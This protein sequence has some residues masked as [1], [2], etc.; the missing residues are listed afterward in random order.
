MSNRVKAT[1]KHQPARWQILGAEIWQKVFTRLLVLFT[2]SLLAVS[3]LPSLLSVE[4]S[5]QTSPSVDPPSQNAAP[6]A[7]S[8]EAMT[9]LLP[10]QWSLPRSVNSATDADTTETAPIYLDGRALFQLGAP[11]VEGQNAAELRAQEIQPKLNRIAK[12][13]LTE[14]QSVEVMIDPPSQLP[15]ITVSNELLLTVTS[16]DAQQNGYLERNQYAIALKENI[17][18]ALER[19]RFERQPDFIKQ[20]ARTAI[21]I[22][23]G[24]LL[25]FALSKRLQK[26]LKKKQI[27]LINTDTQLG[28]ATAIQ[29]R[30]PMI[31]A[32]GVDSVFELIKARLDNRQ[33]RKLNELASGLLLLFQAGILVGATLWILS[34]FPYSRWLATLLRHWI[35][36]PATMLLI[37]GLAYIAL[38]I[39]S[40]MVD[41]TFLALQEGA[42]WAPESSERLSLRLITFS[43]VTKGIAGAF[44]FGVMTLAMLSTAGIEVGPLLAGAGIIG[45]GISL[46]AQGL[47][48]DIINGFLIL[49]EDQFGVGDIIAVGDISGSVESINLRITRLRNTEGRLITIPNS[50]IGIV[51]NL[52]KD[53]SQVDLFVS[54]EP[55][56]DLSL[57][58]T[59]L[60]ETATD[61]AEEADWQ[62]FILEPPDLLG[63]EAID[64]TGI[65]LRLLLKTQPLKQWAVA[66]ELRVRIKQAFDQADISTGVPQERLEIR[67][68]EASAQEV[69]LALKAREQTY[70]AANETASETTSETTEVRNNAS[71]NDEAFS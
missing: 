44:I 25:L 40:L 37:A 35:K 14:K 65:T 42:Q 61:M 46:A 67:W 51:Q 15:V 30:P 63:V 68:E 60:K 38:R 10:D 58:L 12:R 36:I 56:T 32:S 24:V 50:Q 64:S 53:W 69:M 70:K 54:V 21:G 62:K 41:K 43:Q 27:K 47:I 9:R 18:T 52:S 22:L 8:P 3:L 17:E 6:A 16:L 71:A 66:R 33:R 11:A 4:A 7:E 45:V 13:Q 1:P 39:L 55:K 20:Q 49:F 48:K 2:L 5:A 19:Y 59:I 34:L 57:A 23:G 29:A 26:R 28:K 31:V